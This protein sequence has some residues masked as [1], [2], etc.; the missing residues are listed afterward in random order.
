MRLVSARQ[1]SAGAPIEATDAKISDLIGAC[2]GSCGGASSGIDEAEELLRQA[3]AVVRLDG[4]VQAPSYDDAA[5]VSLAASGGH[6]LSEVKAPSAAEVR[7]LREESLSVLSEVQTQVPGGAGRQATGSGG[8]V[9][10]SLSLFGLAGGSRSAATSAAAASDSLANMAKA[11]AAAGYDLHGGGDDSQDEDEE[12]DLLLEQLGEE[13]ALEAKLGG[14]DCGPSDVAGNTSSSRAEAQVTTKPRVVL[15]AGGVAPLFPSA[16]TVPPKPK[17]PLQLPTPPMPGM[18]RLGAGAFSTP[19]AQNDE[20]D[21]WCIICNQD[22]TCR[23]VDCDD[24]AYCSRCW[25]E[26]HVPDLRD[27]RTVPVIRP[28]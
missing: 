18:G 4:G 22:A 24:D 21:N 16:P 7:G 6:A 1:Q 27:H 11:A 13:L 25:R 20:M 23:C 3:A 15:A 8:G 19:V 10:G 26:G 14:A 2:A 17:S 28:R 12:A 9:L 5:L